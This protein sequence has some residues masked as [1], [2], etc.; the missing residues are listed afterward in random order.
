MRA[1]VLPLNAKLILKTGALVC[2]AAWAGFV[3]QSQAQAD[4]R[5]EHAANAFY[6]IYLTTRPTGIPNAA[7][8]AKFSPAISHTLARLLERADSAERHYAKVTKRLVPPLVQGDVFTSLFEGAEN[9]T[10]RDC[11]HT[12]AATVCRVELR[13]GSSSNTALWVDKIHLVR[14]S[15]RWVVDDI[16]YGGDWGFTHKGRL[17]DLLR[18][19]ITDGNH[20]GA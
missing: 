11:K 9:F 18:K 2:C 5:L 12:E 20:A 16:E 3:G 17:K 10:M 8:R 7:I 4:S 19:V 6:R 14:S 1:I 13:Y 15:G